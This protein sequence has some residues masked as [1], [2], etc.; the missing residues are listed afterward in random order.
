MVGQPVQR[1]SSVLATKSSFK[2]N[3]GG[4]NEDLTEGSKAPEHLNT[5]PKEKTG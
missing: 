3:R 2:G 4:V 5:V 1:T